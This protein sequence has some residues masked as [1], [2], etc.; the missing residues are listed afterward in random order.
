MPRVVTFGSAAIR[1]KPEKFVITPAV[2][3]RAARSRAFEP[4]V[5]Q[6]RELGRNETRV[7]SAPSRAA[8]GQLRDDRTVVSR[9][10]CQHG[11]AASVDARAHRLIRVLARTVPSRRV[12]NHVAP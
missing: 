12:R 4:F 9:G 2:P 3:S 1:S 10:A 8:A 11:R 6:A 5:F 7:L